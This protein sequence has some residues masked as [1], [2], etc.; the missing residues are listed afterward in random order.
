MRKLLTNFIGA[1]VAQP[2]KKGTLDHVQLAYQEAI[3][4]LA[5]SQIGSDYDPTKVYILYGCVN[6]DTAPNYDISAGAVFFN[7]EVYLVDAVVFVAADTAVGT[8]TTSYFADATADPVTFTDGVAHN[9]HEIKKMVIA[10]GVSGSGEADFED[11]ISQ[12]WQTSTSTGGVSFGFGTIATVNALFTKWK[13]QGNSVVFNYSLDANI[14]TAG[15]NLL[16]ALTLPVLAKANQYEFASAWFFNNG[17]GIPGY[18]ERRVGVGVDEINLR[19]TGTPVLGG[20][21]VIGQITYEK[22]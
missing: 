14:T 13:S 4:A 21:I 18:A 6:S 20:L 22:G 5:Q 3:N 7:G 16:V 8:V 9:V 2:I 15:T 19:A 1:A 17:I 11:W 12:E 10:D